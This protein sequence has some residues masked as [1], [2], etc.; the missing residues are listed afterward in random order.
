MCD[1]I[2]NK[3]DFDM[4]EFLILLAAFLLGVA[5]LGCKAPPVS[6]TIQTS[7]V[8]IWADKPKQ[9]VS[10]KMEFRR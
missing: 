3:G 1:N 2:S 4:R 7:S 10:V 5:C 8:D 6:Y 9:N